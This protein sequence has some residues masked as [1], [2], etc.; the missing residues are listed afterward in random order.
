MLS[1]NRFKVIV[2]PSRNCLELLEYINNNIQSINKMGIWLQVEKVTRDDMT[3]DLVEIF[4]KNGIT[5][6]PVMFSPDGR[7]FIGTSKIRDIFER[8]ITTMRVSDKLGMGINQPQ[9]TDLESFWQNEMFQQGENG[10]YIPRDDVDPDNDGSL[11]DTIIHK[12]ES[13][14]KKRTKSKQKGKRGAPRQPPRQ[15]PVYE[16]ESE[17]D[18]YGAYEEN[19]EQVGTTLDENTDNRMMQA[20]LQKL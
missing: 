6:L 7:S 11:S 5:R 17:E 19:A 9:A 16:E 3:D 8:N 13:E 20:L 4:R 15:E 10:K 12:K 18:E 14:Y 1:H 2:Q